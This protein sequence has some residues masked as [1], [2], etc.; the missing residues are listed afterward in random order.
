MTDENKDKLLAMVEAPDDLRALCW[1]YREEKGLT[2]WFAL[3][4]CGVQTIQLKRFLDDK[5][6]IS[7]ITMSRI[8]KYLI[9]NN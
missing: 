1:A 8:A 9:E 3:S 2:N 7:T 6:G 4:K 5:L